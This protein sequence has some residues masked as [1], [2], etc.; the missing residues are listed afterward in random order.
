MKSMHVP[1]VQFT[2]LLGSLRLAEY[3]EIW[4]TRWNHWLN[5]AHQII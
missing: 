4:H 1:G 5:R 3:Y 2:A